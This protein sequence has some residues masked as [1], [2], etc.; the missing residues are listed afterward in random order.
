MTGTNMT[1]GTMDNGSRATVPQR[2]RWEDRPWA[3]D[4]A[5]FVLLV[6]G[7]VAVRLAGHDWPNF[8]P[9]A[10]IALFAGYF[11]RS[12]GVAVC[13][14]LSVMALSDWFLGGY[15]WGVMLLVYAA[16]AFPVALRSWLRSTFV[17]GPGRVREA[18]T[19]LAGLWA[20]GILS[21]VL[22]FTV[23][24]FGVWLGFNTY[25]ASWSGLV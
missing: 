8:A 25:E 3:Y 13:V 5:A 23:T 2:G 24:N 17:L 22:F 10:A 16:L 7:G 12:A 15:H 11:F 4:A 6:G 21:S 1:P 18:L 14:P 9:V 19:P 20:C